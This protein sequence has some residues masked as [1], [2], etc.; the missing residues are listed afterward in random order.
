MHGPGDQIIVMTLGSAFYQGLVDIKE[1][2][3]NPFRDDITD[4]SFKM[5]H[6]RLQ[7]ECSAFFKCAMDPPYTTAEDPEPA[8]LPPQFIERQVNTAMY[9]FDAR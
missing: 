5:F 7:N 3:S 8:V 9:D 2:I 6:A 4:Y 1:H